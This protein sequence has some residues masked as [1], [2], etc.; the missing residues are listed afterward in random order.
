MVGRGQEA[1][2]LIV[3][4]T[5]DGGFT[6]SGSLA[7]F[8]AIRLASSLVSGLAAPNRRFGSFKI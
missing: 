3:L 8:T 2:R 1:A 7:I 6:S 4:P 5:S